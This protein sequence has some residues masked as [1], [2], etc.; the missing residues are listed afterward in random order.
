MCQHCAKALILYTL[1][2]MRGNQT[3]VTYLRRYA[4]QERLIFLR[5]RVNSELWYL[6]RI[7]ITET[8]FPWLYQMSLVLV[9]KNLFLRTFFLPFDV[10]SLLRGFGVYFTDSKVLS[11]LSSHLPSPCQKSMIKYPQRKDTEFKLDICNHCY[12]SLSKSSLLRCFL[13][14]K[15]KDTRQT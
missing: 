5:L 10:Y 15:M 14:C 4:K 3:W 13:I 2:F 12:M 6:F 9:L 1:H 11:S 8:Y 7:L